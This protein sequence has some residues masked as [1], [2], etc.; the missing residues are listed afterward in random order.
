[1]QLEEEFLL[2][3]ELKGLNVGIDDGVRAA[4]AVARALDKNDFSESI[5]W[6]YYSKSVRREPIYHR[7]EK[8]DKDYL[9]IFLDATKDVPKDIIGSR[10]GPILKMMSSGTLRGI[11][12]KFANILGYDKLLPMIESEDTYVKVPIQLAERLGKTFSSYIFS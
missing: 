6:E 10:Y 8:I 7:Y 11:A 4:N 5:L 1:M 2:V 12:V 3:Q 9:K